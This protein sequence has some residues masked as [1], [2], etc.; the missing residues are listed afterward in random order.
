MRQLSIS[1]LN[2]I[3]NDVNQWHNWWADR[4]CSGNLLP[5]YPS[6]C[7]TDHTRFCVSV[8][9]QTAS[10]VDLLLAGA[11]IW[12]Q[13]DAISMVHVPFLERLPL[14]PQDAFAKC[15]TLRSDLICEAVNGRESGAAWK[16]IN[17]NG[18]L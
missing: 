10:A 13:R 7:F 15:E 8:C 6:R 9:A 14:G 17:V 5:G 2:K 12:A 3:E 4:H 11:L 18:N 1:L 16:G